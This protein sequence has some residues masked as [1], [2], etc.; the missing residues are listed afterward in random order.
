[1]DERS[2]SSIRRLVSC[3][4]ILETLDDGGLAAAVVSDDHGD[5]GKELDDGDLLVVKGANASNREL[6]QRSHR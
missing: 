6:V 3:C 4:G 5:G 1:M 2:P